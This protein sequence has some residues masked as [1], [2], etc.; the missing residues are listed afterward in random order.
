MPRKAKRTIRRTRSPFARELMR[1]GN[2]LDRAARTAHRLAERARDLKTA[3]D[4]L[5]FAKM[6]ASRKEEEG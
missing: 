1:L 3:D 2:D 6:L 5:A 4:A